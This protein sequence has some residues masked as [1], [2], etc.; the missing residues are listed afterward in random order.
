MRVSVTPIVNL[1]KER[2]TGDTAQTHIKPKKSKTDDTNPRG[3]RTRRQ[4]RE[5]IKS[6]KGMEIGQSRVS[7]GSN[8]WEG[9][10]DWIITKEGRPRQLGPSPLHHERFRVLRGD[11]ANEFGHAHQ[12]I[13]PSDRPSS[14]LGPSGF[15]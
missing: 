10:R 5:I 14:L 8:D 3:K 13:N 7:T 15:G 11:D 4:G 9:G 1:G 2:W 12:T 6:E